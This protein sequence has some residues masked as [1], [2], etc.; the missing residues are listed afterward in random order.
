MTQA[1]QASWL[2]E[3]SF[4]NLKKPYLFH[5]ELEEVEIE[6]HDPDLQHHHWYVRRAIS[7]DS[8]VM[9][10]EDIWLNLTADDYYKLYING[11]F[12]AQ[13][14]AQSDANH[15]YFNK[16]DVRSYLKLGENAIAVHVYYQGLLNRA[17]NSADYRQGL[18][19]ELWAGENLLLKTDGTWKVKRAQD[20]Q[21]GIK[22][23]Y[24]TQ[25][26]ENL[27]ARLTN[28]G[29]TEISY[30]DSEWDYAEAAER[31][32]YTFVQQPTP[33]LAVYKKQPA[34]VKRLGEGHFLIDFGSEL[35]GQFAMSAH[36]NGGDPVHIF[37]GEE[38]MTGDQA[39]RYE[40][41]CNCLYHDQW[42][43]S[44]DIDYFETYDYK[45]FRYVEVQ[46]PEEALI[47]DSFH[48]VVRHYPLDEES[49][50]LHSS[51]VRMNQIFDIC[52]NGVRYGSQ[53]NY[54]DCPSREKG[55]YLGD[56][57]I[58][59]HSHMLL[60]GDLRLYRKAIEQ[61]ARSSF[62]CVGI[63]AV[64]PGHYMQEI[65]DFSLQWPQQLLT[66]YRYSGDKAFLQEMYPFAEGL[67]QHFTQFE[68]EDGL[69]KDVTDKWNLV[70]WP[71][72][73]RDNYD[74]E[75]SRPVSPGCHNVI[76]A[77]YIG[78]VST[79]NEIR[80]LLHVDYENRLPQ[81][82]MSFIK[83]F[84]DKENGLFTDSEQSTHHALHANVLPLLYHIAPEESVTTIVDMIRTK[85]F[86]C[87]V[88][89][90][91]F[92]MKALAEVAEYALIYDLLSADDEH[93]W[94]NMLKEGATTCFEAWGKDQ[95]W[96]TSLCHPWASGP[97]PVLIEDIIGL[98]PAKP[99]WGAIAFR[100]KLPAT[101]TSFS[102][103]LNVPTGTIRLQ[104]E[105]GEWNESFPPGIAV[106]RD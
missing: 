96:N 18:I 101:W 91:Y 90:S 19:A 48:A 25:F 42:T 103:Q 52:K 86:A 77:L 44:G 59:G 81:L 30:D 45:A 26:T 106:I 46:G 7:L 43:L 10:E 12:V 14:P 32:D 5:K 29:W 63:M 58:I 20:N 74:F 50:L 17:Y 35:T 21:P 13:G 41:R 64:V 57:T 61:F 73:L 71:Q 24:D 47:P 55:Q 37:S 67:L 33:L 27:D 102:L 89:F 92:V 104:Y 36:G 60:S 72:N 6:P 23:G 31:T 65:A 40:M 8:Q 85:R 100:P 69:L 68:R 82:K 11:E 76:N 83:A 98:K 9:N 97:V 87:G 34:H 78:C 95:K 84:Y 22:F 3:R 16:I 93:S 2:T 28:R 53:E 66:Y 39:V 62:V 38:L 51:D 1:W 4:T 70:D 88:Y 94:G 99:G 80:D 56:N 79:V 54:V 15:Y 75:L 49:C 105:N